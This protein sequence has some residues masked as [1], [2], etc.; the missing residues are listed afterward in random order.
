MEKF[1]I[2]FAISLTTQNFLNLLERFL[3]PD[4]LVKKGH[5]HPF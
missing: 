3:I 5:T 1:R 4:Y 2:L